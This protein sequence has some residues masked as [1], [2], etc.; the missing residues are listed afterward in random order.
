[1]LLDIRPLADRPHRPDYSSP[2]APPKLT[3][4][5]IEG[6]ENVYNY[7]SV[8][9]W[10]AYSLSILFTLLA[11]M[12][13]ITAFSLN[14]ASYS[15]KFSTMLRISRTA[16]LS[17]ELKERDGSGIDPL[18][19]YLKYARLHISGSGVEAKSHGVVENM[20]EKQSLVPVSRH[21]W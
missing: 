13:G 3:N 17:V 21:S 9:L 20:A 1:M 10:I 19:K 7:D 6:Y 8:T 11:V 5:S 4:V 12:A 14:E 18:P 16:E 15:E 2:F